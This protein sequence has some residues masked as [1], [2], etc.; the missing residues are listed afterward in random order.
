[1]HCVK[2]MNHDQCSGPWVGDGVG[3]EA[4]KS[5]LLWAQEMRDHMSDVDLTTV[6]CSLSFNPS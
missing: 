4:S 5:R 3:G 1:M 2:V 6:K